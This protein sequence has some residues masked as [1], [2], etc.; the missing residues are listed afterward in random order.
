MSILPKVIYRFNAFPV[1]MPVAFFT[2]IENDSKIYMEAQIAK[3]I[4]HKK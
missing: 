3:A 2:E 4:S 1:K